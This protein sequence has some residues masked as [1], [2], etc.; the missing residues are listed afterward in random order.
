MRILPVLAFIAALAV[1]A[2]LLMAA[3]PTPDIQLVDGIYGN[4]IANNTVLNLGGSVAGLPLNPAVRHFTIRNAGNADLS[5]FGG[6]GGLVGPTFGPILNL[7]GWYTY[8]SSLITPNGS[9]SLTLNLYPLRAGPWQLGMTYETNDLDEDP[10]YF[11][12]AGVATQPPGA[13]IL[14]FYN[15]LV[16]LDD[17]VRSQ[18]NYDIETFNLINIPQQPGERLVSYT[19]ENIGA[20]PLTLSGLAFSGLNNCLLRAVDTYPIVVMPNQTTVV[21]LAIRG[22]NAGATCRARVQVRSN[23]TQGRSSYDWQVT[24]NVIPSPEIR[25]LRDN[26]FDVVDGE[27]TPGPRKVN[28]APWKATTVPYLIQNLGTANLTINAPSASSPS[29]AELTNVTFAWDSA[30]TYPL[31]LAPNTSRTLLVTYYP[32]I[33]TPPGTYTFTVS[34][35]NNDLDEGAYQWTITGQASVPRPD[36][37]V[38]SLNNARNIKKNSV[39][40]YP[41]LPDNVV[42]PLSYEISNVGDVDLSFMSGSIVNIETQNCNAVM[43]VPPVANLT[44]TRLVDKVPFEITIEPTGTG[45]WKATVELRSN[46][47]GEDPFRFVVTSYSSRSSGGGRDCGFGSPAGLLLLFGGLT[48]M[49]RRRT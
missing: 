17:V 5:L 38:R 2:P 33:A 22:I 25:I 15:G 3:V 40:V 7:Y 6:T 36:I 30:V 1:Q 20:Q 37:S 14:V 44:M 9:A 10:T 19:V 34:L 31:T 39:D 23:D 35:P 21:T 4:N 11:E 16:I 8:H 18:F 45:L 28:N 26:A 29:A 42:S 47:P 13:S 27:I 41:D 49:R 48:L 32:T 24:G 46:S 12:V 43:S